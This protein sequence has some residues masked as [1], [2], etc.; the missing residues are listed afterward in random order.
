MAYH[1]IIAETRGKVGLIRL[2]RPR[3]LNA[4]NDELMNELGDA[5]QSFETDESIGAI[6]ITGSEKA[7]AAG[8]DVA[9]MK[10][11]SFAE[12]YNGNFVTR[13]WDC[14]SRCRKP[15]IAA[16]AGHALGG[17]CETALACDFIIAADNAVFGQPEVKLAFIPGAGGTQRLPRLIG[18]SRAMEMCLTGRTISATEADRIGLV[19]RVVP[20]AELVDRAV[21]TAALIASYSRPI[22]MM[23]K[24]CVNRASET[25]LAEGLL[26]E[27]RT[28]HSAFALRDQ[29]EGMD[30]FLARRAPTF[31]D[32]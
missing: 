17:G 20:V 1:C 8:A 30:A 32:D 25:P 22:V 24:E 13:N 21:E 15:V 10:D 23:I 5:L 7:F 16:V 11:N 9:E 2:N 14:I 4:L 19:C 18:K 6:V 12:A 31:T 29:K 28:M 26:F 3:H 27:R